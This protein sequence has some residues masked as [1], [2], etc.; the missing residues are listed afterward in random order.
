MIPAPTSSSRVSRPITSS[1]RPVAKRTKPRHALPKGATLGKP[2]TEDPD[3]WLPLKQRA[4]YNP[5]AASSKSSR[6]SKLKRGGANSKRGGGA[7]KKKQG[8][9]GV[10]ATQGSTIEMTP[11]AAAATSSPAGGKSAKGKGKRR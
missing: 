1:S 5:N 9:V 7:S 8:N 10:G 3:R 11:A 4:S 2:F 6:N